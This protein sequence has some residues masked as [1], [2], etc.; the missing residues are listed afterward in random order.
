[1]SG[2]PEGTLFHLNLLKEENARLRG[3]LEE[4]RKALEM[5]DEWLKPRDCAFGLR[6][7][8]STITQILGKLRGEE[9]D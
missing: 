7:Y 4:A 6:H 9:V 8:Q 3:L 2:W 1:M 5:A